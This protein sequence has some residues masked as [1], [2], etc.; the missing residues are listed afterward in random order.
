MTEVNN[1]D[2]VQVYFLESSVLLNLKADEFNA[3]FGVAQEGKNSTG[4]R[5]ES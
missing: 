1:S 2:T 5:A 3:A 4:E